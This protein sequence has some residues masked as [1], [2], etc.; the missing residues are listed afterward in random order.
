MKEAPGKD[1]S[2]VQDA[3][4]LLEKVIQCG[5]A[6]GALVDETNGDGRH[7]YSLPKLGKAILGWSQA[8]ENKKERK[9]RVE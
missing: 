2:S 4:W 9:Q 8:R 3:H 1:N 6:A 5:K 7:Y